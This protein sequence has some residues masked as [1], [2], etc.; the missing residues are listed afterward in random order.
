[1]SSTQIQ[2]RIDGLSGV[3]RK[4]FC[5][6]PHQQAWTPHAIC[7]E[8]TRATGARSEL[9]SVSA[10]LNRLADSGLLR[11]VGRGFQ[12][13]VEIDT[14]AQDQI[15]TSHHTKKSVNEESSP[16]PDSSENTLEQFASISKRLRGMADEIDDAALAM[17]SEIEASKQ[18]SAQ[19]QQLK[20]LLKSIGG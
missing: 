2:S 12:R 3:A 5:A 11:R 16:V 4:I 8:V 10:H 1:M 14:S 6:T 20:T 15:T 7:M 17:Q 18:Q 13:D 9:S 19:L